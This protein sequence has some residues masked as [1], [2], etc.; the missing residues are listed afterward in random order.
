MTSRPPAAIAL[1]PGCLLASA[2]SG[3]LRMLA[4]A[5]D[6]R[7]EGSSWSII[8]PTPYELGV[9]PSWTVGGTPGFALDSAGHAHVSASGSTLRY[10]TDASGQ[11][12][13]TRFSD[14]IGGSATD[15]WSALAIDSLDDVHIVYSPRPMGSLLLTTLH[16]TGDRSVLRLQ[17]D[18]PKRATAM[19]ST[20]IDADD[21]LHIAYLDD[22]MVA[23][24]T[25][26]PDVPS[27]SLAHDHSWWSAPVIALGPDGT[28]HI[29]YGATV[30]PYAN[31]PAPGLL[32]YVRPGSCAAPP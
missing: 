11:W 24:R 27:I 21:R 17:D 10:A 14:E 22:G 28:R 18:Q 3:E 31:L 19:P 4:G 8:A 29:A 20:A 25:D 26:Q 12:A 16:G 2:S 7:R 32:R 13:E 15:S 30:I 5:F 9:G 23:Y 6:L 1:G